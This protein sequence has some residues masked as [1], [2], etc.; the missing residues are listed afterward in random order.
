MRCNVCGRPS[1]NEEANFCEYCGSSFREQRQ[2][3]N[4]TRPRNP[5]YPYPNGPINSMG[6][7]QGNGITG[8]YGRPAYEPAEKPIS[9]K[10]WLG[11]YGLLFIPFVGWLVFVIMLIV[12]SL[13][14][15]IPESKKNWARA[16]LLTTVILT[17]IVA[18]III[19]YIIAVMNTPLYQEIY[20]SYYNE[21][22]NSYK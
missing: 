18:V 7:I 19:L 16:T 11:S 1:Q 8:G 20:N 17:V 4:N 10:S 5:G 15:S 2:N 21:M 6:P 12:W 22:M 14:E 13:S 3:S 9:F